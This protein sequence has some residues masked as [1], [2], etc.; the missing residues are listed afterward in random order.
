MSTIKRI[1]DHLKEAAF[2][3]EKDLGS[4]NQQLGQY[5]QCLNQHREDAD[6]HLVTLLEARMAI[7]QTMIDELHHILS[8]LSP[9]LKPYWEKL[10][11][12]LRSLSGL[13]VRAKFPRAEVEEFHQQLKEIQEALND[14]D[15]IDSSQPLVQQYYDKVENKTNPATATGQELVSDLLARCVIWVQ[16]IQ[17]KPGY[18]AEGFRDL[19]EKLLSMRNALESK[20]LVLAWSLRETDLYDYQRKLDR[21]D[22]SRTEDGN[23]K[24]DDGN[25]A[26]LQ[27]QRVSIQ[28]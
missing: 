26:D 14:K 16:L 3:S 10:V 28:R 19:F 13:N 24:D 12:I 25:K 5:R 2:L 23:F 27:T 17:Q 11:S 1:L 22:E 18:I 21:I 9:E 15:R 8:R 7:C 4:M 20:S 6:P